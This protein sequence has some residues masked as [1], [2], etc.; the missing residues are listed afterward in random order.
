[1]AGRAALAPA[2]PAKPARIEARVDDDAERDA[3][4]DGACLLGRG[5][6]ADPCGG[7]CAQHRD[8]HREADLLGHRGERRGQALFAVRQRRCRRDRV[9]D[10][11]PHVSEA[12]DRGAD[13]DDRH[14]D[15]DAGAGQCQRA[16]RDRLDGQAEQ[17]RAAR[18]EAR[19]D[20]RGQQAAAEHT[21]PDDR[22]SQA[23]REDGGTTEIKRR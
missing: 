6:R 3:V 20:L 14:A 9:R 12:A 21:E 7:D 2:R 19:H 13:Q 1:M 10:R 22:E 15:A 8:A 16:G 17:Q 11:R 23:C 5:R 4:Q 18:A